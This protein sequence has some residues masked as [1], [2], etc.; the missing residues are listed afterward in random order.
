MGG[1]TSVK[2]NLEAFTGFLLV[3]LVEYTAARPQYRTSLAIFRSSYAERLRGTSR[4]ELERK[5]S[6]GLT[7]LLL[8]P[9]KFDV[10]SGAGSRKEDSDR[11]ENIKGAIVN[12]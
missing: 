2:R 6:P 10:S 12:V 5:K 3:G 11:L 1:H 7:M 4:S 8:P 9:T